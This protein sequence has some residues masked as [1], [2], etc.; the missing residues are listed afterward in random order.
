MSDERVRTAELRLSG[1]GVSV[2]AL[3]N[4]VLVGRY[5]HRG[6]LSCVVVSPHDVE[7]LVALLQDAARRI[8]ERKGG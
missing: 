8:L 6:E 3:E 7:H 1:S 4:E 2:R 5:N